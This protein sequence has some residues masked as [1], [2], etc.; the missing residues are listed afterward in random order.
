MSVSVIHSQIRKKVH[1][2]RDA[3]AIAPSCQAA[4]LA[5]HAY[6]RLADYS[7]SAASALN[8]YYS[9]NDSTPYFQIIAQLGIE[10]W[11]SSAINN[12]KI[13][14][15]TVEPLQ[16]TPSPPPIQ[17]VPPPSKYA[18]KVYE[19]EQKRK[20]RRCSSP[21]LQ[22]LE[23]MTA[24]LKRLQG[25]HD[26]P[27][28]TM[29]RLVNRCQNAKT[30][31]AVRDCLHDRDA[32]YRVYAPAILSR[33]LKT[34]AAKLTN[35]EELEMLRLFNI[36]RSAWR[37]KHAKRSI[38][39]RYILYALLQHVVK[40]YA[41]LAELIDAIHMPSEK[42][43]LRLDADYLHAVDGWEEMPQKILRFERV[44]SFEDG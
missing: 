24:H 3:I 17:P 15:L 14:G 20:R 27:Q 31:E 1:E 21:P 2:I 43:L 4:R 19:P 5:E 40:E 23:Y 10:T 8:T 11:I 30:V 16:L 44:P 6:N 29:S 37:D 34:P 38:P 33:V 13:C 9:S 42:T 26:I 28:K 36:F 7:A 25:A 12:L 41:R 35:D 22:N 18:N 39:Y 32:R